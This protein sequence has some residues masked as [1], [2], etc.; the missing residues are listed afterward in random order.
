M[1]TGNNLKSPSLMRTPKM[2]DSRMFV[3][4]PEGQNQLDDVGEP[5]SREISR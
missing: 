3:S 5:G 1:D 2:S 4:G